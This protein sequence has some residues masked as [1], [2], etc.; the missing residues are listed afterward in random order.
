VRAK[1]DD[2]DALL[3]TVSRSGRVVGMALAEPYRTAYGT[4][5]LQPGAAHVSMVFVHP[6]HQRRGI[7]TELVRHL[8]CALP[9]TTLSLWTRDANTAGRRLYDGTGFTRTGDVGAN[10]HGGA[11]SRWERRPDSS[12]G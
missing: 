11:M 3:V 2:P 9:G 1:L 7:G 5:P 10:P 12:H 6:D 4:G 8:V